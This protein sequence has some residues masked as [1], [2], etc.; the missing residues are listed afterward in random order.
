MTRGTWPDLDPDTVRGAGTDAR[1]SAT[2]CRHWKPTLAGVRQSG[3]AG[4]PQRVQRRP[5]ARS[6]CQAQVA[7][8]AG[9][10]ASLPGPTGQPPGELLIPVS[11]SGSGSCRR[12]GTF[13]RDRGDDHVVLGPV[14]AA[15]RSRGDGVDDLAGGSVGHLSED[16]VLAVQPVRG[17]HRD[18]ELGTVG[19]RSGVGHGQQVGLVER[20]LRVELVSELIPGAARTGAGRIPTLDHEAGN[21]AVEDRAVVERAGGPP[22][23]VLGRVLRTAV[24]QRDEVSHGLGGVIGQQHDPDVAVVGVQGRVQVAHRTI[25]PPGPGRN[26][27][28]GRIQDQGQ[29]VEQ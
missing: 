20:Q 18:E 7:I 24:G 15:G 8:G 2:Q 12:V 28:C 1:P 5:V 9:P 27:R 14:V 4:R 3:Q 11:V 10:A 29:P 16:G 19:A 21:D 6:G 23:G 22:G 26:R 25:L 17:G 13:H